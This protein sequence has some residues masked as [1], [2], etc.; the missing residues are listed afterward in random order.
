MLLHA[1]KT[2]KSVAPSREAPSCSDPEIAA[3]EMI[4]IF[5]GEAEGVALSQSR[6]FAR[7]DDG[8]GATVWAEIC[9]AIGRIRQDQAALSR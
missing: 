9:A 3:L 8:D 7:R 1:F 5:A 2:R 6:K 4:R